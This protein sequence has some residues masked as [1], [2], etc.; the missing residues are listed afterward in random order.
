MWTD[1]PRAP[2]HVLIRDV[3]T[4]GI[5]NSIV[6]WS[7]NYRKNRDSSQNELQVFEGVLFYG[8][9]GRVIF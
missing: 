2:R 8:S 4:G 1:T 5:A 6:F 7:S 9:H 3:L